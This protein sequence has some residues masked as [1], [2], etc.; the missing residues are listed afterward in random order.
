MYP[1]LRDG[2]TADQAICTEQDI[3]P[4]QLEVFS[5]LIPRDGKSEVVV[6]IPQ[7]HQSGL[8]ACLPG[9]EYHTG[10]DIR[11]YPVKPSAYERGLADLR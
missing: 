4:D 1:L 8:F 7:H 9:F 10:V 6:F 11:I 3:A 2:D 5:V